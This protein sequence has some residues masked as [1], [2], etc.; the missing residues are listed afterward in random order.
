M[1]ENTLLSATKRNAMGMVFNFQNG[2]RMNNFGL[3]KLKDGTIQRKSSQGM[4]RPQVPLFGAG[5]DRKDDSYIN[6]LRLRKLK[7]GYKVFFSKKKHW[8]G[9]I[10]LDVLHRI[11]EDGAVFK[12][13]ETVII[14]PPRPAFRKAFIR[15]LKQLKAQETASEVKK[16][17][18]DYIRSGQKS[19]VDKYN[20]FLEKVVAIDEVPEE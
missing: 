19:T 14:I 17:Y 9:T 12:R 8:S 2:I 5:D 7:N 16:V 1:M 13:G 4:E 10:T 20:R 3:E 18:A 11:H 6:G 15:T